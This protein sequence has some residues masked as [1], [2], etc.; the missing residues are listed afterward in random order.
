MF[1]L[2][3]SLYGSVYGHVYNGEAAVLVHYAALVGNHGIARFTDCRWCC[4]S[5]VT[6]RPLLLL[7]YMMYQCIVYG[8]SISKPFRKKMTALT[9]G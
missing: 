6:Q 1:F 8:V 9:Y 3:R 4:G 2:D 5:L 7:L